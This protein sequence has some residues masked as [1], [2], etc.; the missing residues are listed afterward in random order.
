MVSV[1]GARLKDGERGVGPSLLNLVLLSILSALSPYQNTIEE[2]RGLVK[3]R[4]KR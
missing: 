2:E 3:I 4:C 1:L